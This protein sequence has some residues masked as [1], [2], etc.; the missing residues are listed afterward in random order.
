MIRFAPP[1]CPTPR[2]LHPTVLGF[3]GMTKTS[4][5]VGCGRM[6]R[7]HS[8]GGIRR[9]LRAGTRCHSLAF[10]FLSRVYLRQLLCVRVTRVTAASLQKALYSYL[11]GREKTADMYAF[12]SKIPHYQVLSQAS[13]MLACTR[14][15]LV[16][17][18]MSYFT[19]TIS[20]VEECRLHNY[21][22]HNF[23]ARSY[24]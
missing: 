20:S 12:S 14:N 8:R 21:I 15:D 16:Y 9:I 24:Y 10:T 7:H 1:L 17:L 6:P 13:E 2:P 3:L 5:R 19:S 11:C 4:S 23:A 22:A 18:K